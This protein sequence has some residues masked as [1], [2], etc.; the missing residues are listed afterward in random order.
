MADPLETCMQTLLILIG[1]GNINAIGLAERAIDEFL[2]SENGPDTQTGALHVLDR[3]LI[4]I[5]QELAPV[6]RSGQFTDAVLAYVDRR[7]QSL[8]VSQ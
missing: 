1:E 4:T 3:R 6:S 2:N 7:M 8:R 5:R